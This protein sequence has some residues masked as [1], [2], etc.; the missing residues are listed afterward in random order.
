MA[1]K[2]K[3]AK[4][5]KAPSQEAIKS[6]DGP[7]KTPLTE[8]VNQ[9]RK[10]LVELKKSA[11]SEELKFTL[12]EVEVELQVGLTWEAGGKIG[13]DCWFYKAELSPSVNQA[14]TQTIKLKLKPMAP[15]GGTFNTSGSA[16]RQSP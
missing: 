11:E 15:G 4:S 5:V 13:F 14:T 3:P 8:V 6:Q 12:E 7:S 2:D 10:E 9:L 1:N 16:P